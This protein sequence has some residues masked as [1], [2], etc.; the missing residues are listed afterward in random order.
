M[1]AT[2]T[3]TQRVPELHG[4]VA[5]HWARHQPGKRDQIGELDAREPPFAF[6]IVVLELCH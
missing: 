3:P 6:D 4:D 2:S 5:S 1:P